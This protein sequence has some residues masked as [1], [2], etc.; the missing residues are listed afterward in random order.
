MPPTDASTHAS[1]DTGTASAPSNEDTLELR[2]TDDF[3]ALLSED[4][5]PCGGSTGAGQTEPPANGEL[6]D[7]LATWGPVV[8]PAGTLH[9]VPVRL[10]RDLPLI[11]R[12]MNDSAVDSY[13][14][15]GGTEDVAAHHLRTQLDGD[16]RSMPCLGL[17]NGTPLSYWE[18][19]RADLDPL[20][21]HYPAR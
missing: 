5:A 2:L 12:W 18:I 7:H 17:L 10:E 6:L 14:K 4:T 11:S 8:T 9:L 20:A 16:G 13:W 15:L 1:T 21:R 3:L 19:Y